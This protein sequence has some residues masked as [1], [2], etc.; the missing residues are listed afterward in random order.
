MG[1]FMMKYSQLQVLDMGNR[2]G[3]G[4]KM[5]ANALGWESAQAVWLAGRGGWS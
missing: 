1:G 5:C 3:L 4:G 2:G